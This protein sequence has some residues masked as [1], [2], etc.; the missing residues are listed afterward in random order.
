[1][2]I[3]ADGVSD[4]PITGVWS[5][6]STNSTPIVSHIKLKHRRKV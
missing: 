4:D 1:L 6:I 5:A 2:T 3:N